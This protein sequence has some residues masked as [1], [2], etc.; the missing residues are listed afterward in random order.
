M[1]YKRQAI[2]YKLLALW[3]AL[4]LSQLPMFVRQTRRA[5]RKNPGMRIIHQ[6]LVIRALSE[7]ESILPQEITS[8][9]SPMPIK[10]SVDSATIAERTFMTT[11]NM[12][13]EIKLGAR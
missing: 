13:D 9:G 1:L 6:D 11:M 3:F 12:T 5:T 8:I 2:F 7:S 4:C 10:L